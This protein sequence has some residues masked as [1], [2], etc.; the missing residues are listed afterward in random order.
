MKRPPLLRLALASIA[1]GLVT[2]VAVSAFFAYKFTGPQR[3]SVP[4][5]PAELPADTCDVVF[6]ARDGV[7]LRGWYVPCPGA[8]TAVVLLHGHSSNRRQMIARARFF[9]DHGCAALLYDARGHGKSDGSL[10]SVGWYETR[11]LLGAL[12]YLRAQ[13]FRSFG[14][15]GVSQGG[16]TIALAA[17][18]LADVRWV[19]LES[20][21]PTLRLALDHR[22][23]HVFHL[24][25]ALAG[26]LLVPLAEHRLGVDL[27]A[28]APAQTVAQLHCPSLIAS[29]TDDLSTPVSDTQLLFAAAPSPKKLWLVPGVG[30][31][32]LYGAAP[33][34]YEQHLLAF[35]AAVSSASDSSHGH[36]GP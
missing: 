34:R 32:D 15:L 25:L 7:T 29:G 27:D 35:L 8:T 33:A 2:F 21:Y 17:G 31:R 9:H 13:G 14:C 23:R 20:T 28:I 26:A 12:D 22:F 11:D 18:Q 3:R 36:A 6:P 5:R 24:P 16:A 10:T 1:F 19:V 4:V 30:H